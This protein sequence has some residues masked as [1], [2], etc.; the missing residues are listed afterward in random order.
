M[1]IAV[2]LWRAWFHVAVLLTG[3]TR[4]VLLVTAARRLAVL[5]TTRGR[6]CDDGRSIATAAITIARAAATDDHGPRIQH[7]RRTETNQHQIVQHGNLSVEHAAH[8]IANRDERIESRRIYVER[9]GGNREE[10]GRLGF[11]VAG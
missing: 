3:I 9:Q 8:A 10:R 2:S 6:R 5:A 11:G 7:F 4:A 1:F